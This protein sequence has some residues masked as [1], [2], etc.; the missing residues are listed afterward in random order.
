MTGLIQKIKIYFD[1]D[2][3]RKDLPLAPFRCVYCGQNFGIADL[4]Q[5][6]LR[7]KHGWL[8]DQLGNGGIT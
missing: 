5:D 3:T 7:E 8:Y 4:Y 6:H 1:S 2:Y